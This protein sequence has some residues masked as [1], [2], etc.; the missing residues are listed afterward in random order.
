[1]EY[2]TSEEI[3]SFG[4]SAS[5]CLAVAKHVVHEVFLWQE[6]W[7]WQKRPGVHK[8]ENCWCTYVLR[9]VF[10]VWQ[11]V[12]CLTLFIFT[13]SLVADALNA[14]RKW[15]YDATFQKTEWWW[16]EL[17]R[18][19]LECSNPF[20]FLLLIWSVFFLKILGWSINSRSNTC[21]RIV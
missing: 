18:Q 6:A 8:N 7:F 15:K 21:W 10:F 5:L 19:V 1:M 20:L 9:T 13:E 2:D 3:H 17:S 12:W 14:A 16:Q 4:C 11:A